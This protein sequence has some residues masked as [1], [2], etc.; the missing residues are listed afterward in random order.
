MLLKYKNVQYNNIQKLLFAV[1][2]T[3][4]ITIEVCS[5]DVDPV[6]TAQSVPFY[7]A[8]ACLRLTWRFCC[9]MD[10]RT[11]QRRYARPYAPGKDNK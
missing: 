2:Q 7:D 4:S 6:S 1:I 8:N 10:K 9:N 3:K 5:A 11:D